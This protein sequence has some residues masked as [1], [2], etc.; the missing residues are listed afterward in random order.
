MVNRDFEK[1]IRI[2]RLQVDG[3]EWLWLSWTDRGLIA[4]DWKDPTLPSKTRIGNKEVKHALSEVPDLYRSILQRYFRGDN[5]EPAELP[6]DLRG[7][8]FQVAVWKAL[9]RIPRGSVRS[10][11]EIAAFIGYPRAAR[12]VGRANRTNPL[13]VVVPCHR[14][15]RS[16]MR[17]GGFSGGLERKL[18]LLRLE[19]IALGSNGLK[20]E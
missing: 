16:G 11:G 1:N 3:L 15:V 20:L 10:Y 6:V 4:I 7:T 19:G 18:H 2:G 9:R 12:A 5:V 14:V 17:L 8:D 13:P